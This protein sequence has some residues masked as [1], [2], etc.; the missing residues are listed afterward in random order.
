MEIWFCVRFIVLVFI[1]F[2]RSSEW[3]RSPFRK[4]CSVNGMYVR[5]LNFK[6]DM[7]FLFIT[8]FSKQHAEF[9]VDIFFSCFL[10]FFW[11]KLN[12]L[13]SIWSKVW[14]LLWTYIVEFP[15][16][17][18]KNFS[19]PL[20]RILSLF[21]KSMNSNRV[22]KG[23]SFIKSWNIKKVFEWNL[24]LLTKIHSLETF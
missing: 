4:W 2:K 20:F 17:A 7:K 18:R 21:S 16:H 3:D 24:R 10:R 15:T 19:F 9:V 5:L 8:Q 14:R 13:F 22:R 23:G 6:I 1:A 12:K 11:N